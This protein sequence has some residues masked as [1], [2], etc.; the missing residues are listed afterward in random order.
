VE[1]GGGDAEANS[2]I[3]AKYGKHFSVPLPHAFVQVV[4]ISMNQCLECLLRNVL[5][6][7]QCNVDL[8]NIDWYNRVRHGRLLYMVK[9]FISDAA[10]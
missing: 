9:A 8:I 6:E 10:M 5:C 7:H 2:R 4:G 3:F 1:V